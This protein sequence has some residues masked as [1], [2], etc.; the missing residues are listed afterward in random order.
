MSLPPACCLQLSECLRTLFGACAV[1]APSDIMLST[2][3]I[4]ARGRRAPFPLSLTGVGQSGWD[5]HTGSATLGDLC[6]SLP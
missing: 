4:S 3:R 6:N 1:H 2:W 5:Q